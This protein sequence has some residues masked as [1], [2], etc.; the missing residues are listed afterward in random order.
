MDNKLKELISI[1]LDGEPLIKVNNSR[2]LIKY[3]DY[4][5][6]H[7]SSLDKLEL[8]YNI[9]DNKYS[10]TILAS[11]LKEMKWECKTDS[12]EDVV[13]ELY[14]P[15]P[16]SSLAE[17]VKVVYPLAIEEAKEKMKLGYI[18]E[19]EHGYSYFYHNNRFVTDNKE[20]PFDE[21]SDKDKD[22]RYRLS[23]E[24]SISTIE[25]INWYQRNPLDIQRTHRRNRKY[26]LFQKRARTTI[27]LQQELSN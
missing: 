10:H 7:T 11:E 5:I 9:Y 17:I 16:V 12:N 6:Q 18:V 21:L 14:A 22:R 4:S 23:M 19:N 13:V 24:Q 3:S 27:E 20:M 26:W 15:K 2:F 25:N 1:L 8:T